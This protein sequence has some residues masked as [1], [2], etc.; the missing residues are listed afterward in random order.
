MPRPPHL[1][2]HASGGT[3]ARGDPAAA[4]PAAGLAAGSR[5]SGA[6]AAHDLHT[7]R[8]ARLA[9]LPDLVAHRILVL[10][11]AMGT[12][13]QAHRLS[14][15]DFRGERFADHPHDLRGD[16]DLLV[17]TRPDIVAAVHRAYLEAG[18]DII[19]T[20]TFN[21]NRISQADYGLTHLARELNEAAASLARAAADEAEA[22]DPARPRYVA[23]AIGPTNKTA[24]LSPDVAD[25]AARNVTFEALVEAYAEAAEGLIAGGADLLLV[26]TIFDTLNA[27]AAIFAIETVFERLGVRLPVMLSG[28]VVDASGR[29]LSGQTVEAFFASVA[30]ANPF[31]VGLNCALGARQLR[32]WLADLA[33]VAPVP[34]SAYPNAGL[35][36]EFGGYDETPEVTAGLIAEWA[37]DGLVNIVGGCCG[38]T[39]DHVRAIAAAVAGIPPRPIPPRRSG[40]LTL[41]GLEP[42]EIPQP[43]GLLVHVGERTNVTGS[44]RFAR[45]V[46]TGDYA[47]AVE[48]AR[49]QVEAGANV[50]DVNMDEAM[51]DSVA[52]MTTFLRLLA[53]EPSVARVPIMVD[54]SRWEVIE[55]GLRQVQGKPVVNSLSL[56]DGEAEFLRRARLA[57][58]YGAAV[59]VMAF[60]EAGQAET[61]ERKVEIAK[62]AVRL[63]T[64]EVG[65]PPEEIIVD[66][67]VFAVGTGIEEHAGYG[68]AFIEAV[69]RIKADL[70]GVKTSGGISNVSFAFRGNDPVREAIHAVFL[71]HAVRAGLDLAIVNAAALPVYD[72]IEPELRERA[73]DLVLARRPDATERLLEIADR[74]RST[75]RAA[76]RDTAW[77]SWP[78]AERLRHALVEGISEYIA[79]DTEEA[80]RALGSPLAVIEGP[81]MDGMRVVGDLFGAGKM[82]L[83][84]VVKSARVMKQAV[85][86]LVPYLEAEAAA[87]KDRAAGRILLATVKGDVHDIGKNIVGV[88]LRCNNY[89]VVDLGVMVPAATILETAR[90]IR[91]DIVGLSGLITPSLDEMV[92]VAAEMERQGFRI[93]LLIGGAT[94][95]RTH[96]AVKIAPVYSGP[97]VHVLDASRA[98]GVASALLSPDAHD[99]FVGEIRR[100]YEAIRRERDER[101]AREARLPLAE[102]RANRLEIDWR[103]R[104]VPRPTFLGTRTFTDYPIADL[105]DR[106]DWTPFFAAWELKGRFPAILDDPE[107]GQA[108]RDLYADAR[109][110]LERIEREG[111]LRAAGVVGFWP[112]ASTPDDDIECYADESR[113]AVVAVFRTLR[114]QMAKPDGR[115]NLALADFVAPRSAGIVDYIG[116]FAVTAGLG[117]DEAIA[118]FEAAHDPYGAIMIKALADR[119]AEAFAER[120]HERVRREL[121]GYAPDEA[122]SNEDLIAERYQGIRPAPGY[123]A[124]PDHTEKRTIFALLG[125]ER[126]GMRLTESCA[127]LPAASVAG[128]YFW[129]PEASYFGLGRIGRDQLEDYA[130][131]KGI[132]VEEAARWL[133][134]NLAEE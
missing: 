37:R 74:A 131:R 62:R 41:A 94:T 98:V 22:A 109:R 70:P 108:A 9:R 55:A 3:L 110:M 96:T 83:P 14:E 6:P 23:G 58:R 21:A 105:V 100:E 53:A 85:A 5:A 79:A 121:W 16:N 119:L 10:D 26:E 54:S 63:L 93:P 114:Q 77:R 123:P 36:N 128:Y 75:A 97:T 27:K 66:P 30:H 106:I 95:S 68:L 91:A 31:S 42:L 122:L 40:V 20:N 87:G 60:D 11:G 51:L 107:R 52:A 15:A 24:S 33:R 28:T 4:A 38:T 134:P 13:L 80:R 2:R 92:H 64:E 39:P 132:S 17:L 102:A 25:P 84:Q 82:F 88:V 124:C 89:D 46:T 129:R 73:E 99:R 112:A 116:A 1:P 71:Y 12:M 72:D 57:R 65:F 86:V 126:V 44:R 125:A 7:R 56:K 115:P 117:A 8:A 127:M 29:T 59:V 32:G 35:P 113:R 19:E 43:G 18:A 50:L 111:L 81:L 104:P 49:E 118:R 34:V 101:Q 130:R 61:V 69:R 90:E 133:R 120:L 45:L 76:E 67:N 103:T 48:V 78:V 47:A